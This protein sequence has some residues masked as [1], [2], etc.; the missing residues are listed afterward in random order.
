[1]T[2]KKPENE[3]IEEKQKRALRIPAALNWILSVDTNMPEG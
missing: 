1:V 2:L 3:K